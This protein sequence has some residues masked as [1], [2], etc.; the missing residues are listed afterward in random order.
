MNHSQHFWLEHFV[1]NERC[2]IYSSYLL[3]FLKSCSFL[4]KL[5]FW[6]NL[7]VF[8]DKENED[9]EG[10]VIDKDNVIEARMST[11]QK[12]RVK[13]LERFGEPAHSN[14]R[15]RRH[16]Q[17]PHRL[18][19]VEVGTALPQAWKQTVH[20]DRYEIRHPKVWTWIYGQQVAGQKGQVNKCKII[21]PLQ[22]S[23][24]FKTSSD[25]C[26]NRSQS[27]RKDSYN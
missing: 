26:Q 25:L 8:A 10:E 15:P 5:T 16:H 24:V 21:P 3:Y 6:P 12:V 23:V 22:G 17:F 4:T 27:K 9:E 20:A 14:H 2:Y 11:D 7:L 18:L 13:I 1:P 19:K